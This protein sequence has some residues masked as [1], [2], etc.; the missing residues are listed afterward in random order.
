[1]KKLLTTLVIFTLGYYALVLVNL[2]TINRLCEGVIWLCFAGYYIVR[3]RKQ[4]DIKRFFLTEYLDWFIIIPIFL[5]P[6]NQFTI[7]IRYIIF[8][9]IIFDYLLDYV[10]DI[11]LRK[12]LILVFLIYTVILIS[13]AVGFVQFEGLSFGQGLWLSF[14]SSTTV[15]YGD[16]SA[17]TFYGDLVSVY[18]ITAGTIVFGAVLISVVMMLIE[19]RRNELIQEAE[20]VESEHEDL[21]YVK[22][23]FNKFRNG[24]LTLDELE[25]VVINEINKED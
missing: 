7:F 19:E 23:T 24:K 4:D 15:G 9:T 17:V 22:A 16:V 2:L 3:A 13:G 14:I 21:D 18:V 10:E 5:F 8:V 11:L 1:M 12:P 25:K 6:I 20:T